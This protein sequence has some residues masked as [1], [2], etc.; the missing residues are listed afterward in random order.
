MTFILIFTESRELKKIHDRTIVTINAKRNKQTKEN[1]LSR[2]K[3]L[4]RKFLDFS[5]RV[6]TYS[7]DSYNYCVFSSIIV[8]EYMVIAVRTTTN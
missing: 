4:L 6:S 2:K 3:N 1:N 8:D 5:C 7:K